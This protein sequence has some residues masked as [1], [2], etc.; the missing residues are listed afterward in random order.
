MVAI[1]NYARQYKKANQWSIVYIIWS[2]TEVYNRDIGRDPTPYKFSTI[3]IVY[4]ISCWFNLINIQLIWFYWESLL[5]YIIKDSN[6]VMQPSSLLSM[7][8]WQI[9]ILC[10]ILMIKWTYQLKSVLVNLMT[11]VLQ[12]SCQRSHS[13]LENDFRDRHLQCKN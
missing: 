2:R 3:Q 10:F 12:R 5:L 13:W 1:L 8:R 7:I 9:F 4:Q 11:E 6:Y